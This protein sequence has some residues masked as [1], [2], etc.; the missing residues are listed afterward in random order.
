MIRAS[1]SGAL[2]RLQQLRLEPRNRLQ[3]ARRLHL[4]LFVNS[5]YKSLADSACRGSQTP[6]IAARSPRLQAAAGFTHSCSQTPPTAVPS[7]RLQAARRHRLQ[8]FADSAYRRLQ[9]TST[10][11]SQPPA[12]AYGRLSAYRPLADSAYRP[13]AYSCGS[14]SMG[15]WNLK[16]V[17]NSSAA[18][19]NISLY[20]CL[21]VTSATP[22]MSPIS[23]WVFLS[24]DACEAI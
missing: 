13:A 19:G 5:A 17:G 16:S 6:P 20:D 11:H 21:M 2:K 4:Q 1:V 12:T 3:A 23:F 15:V 9:T 8:L 22:A 14:S 10:G 18:R 24:S 7:P